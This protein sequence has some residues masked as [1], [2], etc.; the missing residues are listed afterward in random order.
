MTEALAN[1][2]GRLVAIDTRDM[3]ASNA[4]K[5]RLEYGLDTMAARYDALFRSMVQRES[6]HQTGT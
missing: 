4:A 2:L 5:A 3:G 6:V 1:A